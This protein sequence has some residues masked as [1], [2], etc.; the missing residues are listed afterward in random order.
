MMPRMTAPTADEIVVYAE[1]ARLLDLDVAQIMDRFV[2]QEALSCLE[3]H[4]QHTAR[5]ALQ[6][7][8]ADR[9]GVAPVLVYAAWTSEGARH[10]LA[11]LGSRVDRPLATVSALDYKLA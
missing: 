6:H 7:E 8:L 2:P 1:L 5:R 11:S 3:Y 10:L 9:M 4:R